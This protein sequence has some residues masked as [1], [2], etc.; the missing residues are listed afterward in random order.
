[1]ETEGLSKKR[2]CLYIEQN[3]WREFKKICSREDMKMSRK[4]TGFVA[5]YVAVHMKG[6]PQLMLDPFIRETKGKCYK[7][8]GL[9]PV[10]IPVKFLSNLKRK[11][12][13]TCLEE[14]QKRDL[15]K[16]IYS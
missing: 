4:I 10:L 12:C 9:F 3:L 5:R 14:Y 2:I 8:R 6:N 15:I 7:C 16:K 1:M 11:V 13:K